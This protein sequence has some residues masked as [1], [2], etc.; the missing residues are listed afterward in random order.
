MDPQEPV[1]NDEGSGV[2][3]RRISS[4]LKAPR[5]SARFPD[6]EQQENVVESARPM[7]KRNSRR[8]SFAP[9]NDVLLF[10]KDV[11]N[12]PPARSPLLEL[13]TAVGA[14]TQNR[15]Q[16][17]AT[18]DGTQQIMGMA[19]LLNAPLHA[20][21]QQHKV[22]FDNAWEFGEKTMIFSTDDAFMDVTHSHT[23]NIASD[24]SIAD[25][26]LRNFDVLPTGGEKAVMF[27]A[28][29]ASMDTPLSRTINM[30]KVSVSLPT[31]RN[32]ES[33]VEK[34]NL[35]SSIPS[36][37]PGFGNFLA[38]LSKPSGP[39]SSA[40]TET[41]R[42]TGHI[43]TQNA[44]LD[45]E[46][47]IPSQVSA[48]TKKSLNT[49]GR[50]R[51]SFHGSVLCP[52]VDVSMDMTEA[53]TGL[54]LGHTDDDDDP[55]R[56]LFPT[57]DMYAHSERRASETT[58]VLKTKQQQSD[59]MLGYS[60]PK[61]TASL[62]DSSVHIPHPGRKVNFVTG[63]ECREKTIIFTAEDEF[64]DMT[65]SH[66]INIAH[67]P[68]ASPP[69][70]AE[71][72][73]LGFKNFLARLSDANVPSVNPVI[74][75]I[76]PSTATSSKDNTNTVS[77]LSYIEKPMA[78]V[79]E[80]DMSMDMTAVHTG[81][82]TGISASDDPFQFLL[83]TQ[84]LYVHSESQR[85]AEVTSGQKS[86][87][88]PGSHHAGME[89]S[90]KPSLK[91]KL[92]THQDKFEDDCR[93]KTVRFSADDACMDVTR[94][95]TVNI[96][97]EFKVQSRQS[98]GFSSPCRE[99]TVRFNANDAAMD[100][101]ECL[102]VN[103][104]SHLAS[105]SVHPVKKQEGEICG[106][107]IDGSSSAHGLDNIR[108]SPNG[109]LIGPEDDVRMNMEAQTGKIL[110]ILNTGDAPLGLF[111]TQAKYSQSGHLKE[112][113][114]PSQLQHSKVSR[115]SNY[116]GIENSMKTSWKMK[117]ERDQAEF[118]AKDDHVEKTV[119]FSADDAPMEV[120]QS[121]TV[122]IATHFEEPSHPNLGS[123]PTY[124]EKTATFPA[125]NA[126]MGVMGSHSVNMASEFELLS[127]H[128]VDHLPSYGEKTVKF[129]AD[130]AAIDLTRSHTVN[131]SHLVPHS[132]QNRDPFPASG[133]KTMRFNENDAAMD[134]T[135]S[136]TVA[137][138]HLVPQSQQNRD[139]FPASGE[140]TM[141][142]NENDAA[143]DV[144]RSH[145]VAI[146]HLVPQ[147]QQNRDPFPASGEK[148]M[149]F[150]EN[151]AAM[152]VMRSHTVA[153][154]H[155][156]PQ[157]QQ[158]RDPFPASGEKTVRFNENDAA[159]DVTRSH[160]VAISHL[161]PQS[162]QNRDT[163][164]A[165]GEKTVRFNA[166]EA[167]MDVTH[168]HTVNIA[169]NFVLTSH[170]NLDFGPSEK[171][172]RFNSNYAAMDMTQ[173][174]TVNIA[175]NAVSDSAL[176]HQESNIPS[177]H[178]DAD[179]S[180]ILKKGA[181][182]R[183]SL[184]HGLDPGI[185]NCQS[186][187]SDPLAEPVI[188][189]MVTPPAP[190]SLGGVSKN[191]YI[192]ELHMQKPD[193]NTKNVAPGFVPAPMEKP[194]YEATTD[195]PEN[196]VTM[197]MTEAQTGH[198][199]WQTCSDGL[200]Q[201]ASSAQD[202]SPQTEA[203]SQLNNEALGSSSPNDVEVTNC[204]DSSDVNEIA[205]RKE[206]AEPRNDVSSSLKLESSPSAADQDA[207]MPDS[208]KSRRMSLADIESKVRRLSYMI[209]TAP[210]ITAEESCTPPLVQLD[211][212]LDETAK[213][214]AKS[215]PVEEPELEMGL[216]NRDSQDNTQA[217][218]LNQGEEA[219]VTATPFNL[220][221][222]QLMSRLSVGGF[223]PK[224]PQRAKA[225]D[226]K[227][228]NS[229]GE[230]TK[231]M[232][233]NLKN[234]M[235]SFDND[236]SDIYD[237][238]LGSCED[239]SEMLDT[240]SP[241]K[242]SEK[243]SHFEF[244]IELLEED[245]FEGDCMSSAQGKK[246]PLPEDEGKM[247]DEKRMKASDTTE[248][249]LHSHFVEG[250]GNISAAP[251]MT[252]HTADSSSGCHTTSIRCE[253]AYESTLK[254]SLFE[255]Q[256]EDYASDVQK[257]LDDGTITV[258][259]FFK[260]FNIDFVIHNPRQSV[261]PGKLLSDKDRTPMDLLKD[262]HISRPKQMVYE[263]D[264]RSLT[265]K[266]EGLKVRMRDLEKPLKIVSRPLWEEMRNSSEKELKAFGAKLKERNNVFRKMSKAQS[267]EMKEVLYSV[268][269]QANLEE[270]QKL[271]GIIEKA[272]EMR[273]SLDDC[274]RD[275][276]TELAAVEEKGS[277]DKRSLKSCQ[278]EMRKVTETLA[279]SERQISE[280]ELQKKQNLTKIKRLKAET[281]NL[282]SHV[283][284]LEILNEWKFGEKKD[285]CTVYTFLHDTM[286]LQL[287]YDTYKDDD[288]QDERKIS[289]ITFKL[290]LDDEK[291]QCH[292]RLVHK[293]VS[294]YVEGE[295][296][297]VEK[298]PTSRHVPKLLHD[299]SL[300]V[301]RCRLL[302][303][304]LRLL[305]MWGGLRLDILDVSCVHTQ[306]HIIFSSLKKFS[307][308]EVVFSVSLINHLCVLQI[309]SF[310]NVIGSTELKQIED[311]VA[312]YSPAKNVL[313]KIVKKIHNDLLR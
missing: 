244:D 307:K 3:K 312:S 311:I 81:H 37:D 145:T 75:R 270:Q 124:G 291:S 27:A 57:Q 125:D 258:L 63:D 251:N 40:T 146:S 281:K 149:R 308:F 4:I 183:S 294:Q 297:W 159:M 275:L 52:E 78:D 54:I 265:E 128:H 268:L 284:V 117:M 70:S 287:I 290:Q 131:I 2:S 271:R 68:L 252:A 93:E 102:T 58:E 277:V 101:T 17:A 170:Q 213:D 165:S 208:Q 134:V 44:D 224:L 274:I 12:D 264:V 114:M 49:S 237:E 161:V 205:N 13:M 132:Q 51:E 166:N 241:Q 19:T 143:M 180:L 168:S 72:F 263:T 214:E 148:T 138:S 309:E 256:L 137:I 36:L 232:T 150:N 185:K 130:D 55:F 305:K 16:L 254:H 186:K 293:L 296:S 228:G 261:L 211:H 106:P 313:T 239:M 155:L 255:S 192:S 89:T 109:D 120:T 212:N 175:S 207:D 111:P 189:E 76:V 269:V 71:G 167:G 38:S 203:I 95:H 221:T 216:A 39:T 152:D 23:I 298:Y 246:R 171:T 222:K 184:A 188:T 190:S 276:E 9:A 202:S 99:K 231:T 163:F 201:H 104:D 162:Q 85:K 262:K 249:E 283:A 178:G 6:P 292:S 233:L 20:S 50:T 121:H 47:Q 236:V 160:T 174:L 83:P 295:T 196:N 26:S 299:V 219:S 282:E 11:K 119:R 35:A 200:P 242:V 280:L 80:D 179:L 195:C 30:T 209:N 250:D 147:S 164:P 10:S 156:V 98:L 301:S 15:V 227:K 62:K 204:P 206:P 176:P 133:E 48:M 247:E 116:K 197:D 82:I 66:T 278:E 304:E 198:N 226:P 92:Q 79:C 310:K 22:S 194:Q 53:Q 73:D 285:N 286:H 31:G 42:T 28:G 115:S 243:L 169:S 229:V 107:P 217:Q 158:N 135:R 33:S 14:T 248:M 142:F 136:H 127:H 103:I 29:D 113:E 139:P 181:R 129:T 153:I 235:S 77:S 61:G 46:N 266:V 238:E 96:A 67:G 110:G 225:G 45:K 118:D 56:C 210:Y 187:M 193:M 260:L 172:T 24:A 100:M 32:V 84:D 105:E 273:K 112:M 245:V 302:G 108:D 97:T 90:M 1:K 21:Q 220:K 65:Q 64:M 257:K 240:R 25:I 18:E 288:N 234:Q 126:H 173:C 59:K 215:L 289:D 259:E 94:S 191:S 34:R 267:H 7:E 151:D 144:T 199:L 41:N 69:S 303:E 306:V 8:V 154:S 253:T 88:A 91:P 272:D 87:Q 122:N 223:K 157:S 60:E 43:K 230:Q 177:T 182:S 74:E 140:K 279:D 218:C 86:K 5:K 141:R 300:V 123:L